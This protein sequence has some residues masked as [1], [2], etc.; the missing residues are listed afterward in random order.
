MRLNESHYLT[1][2]PCCMIGSGALFSA[3]YAAKFAGGVSIL[4]WIIGAALALL[5]AFML[6]EISTMYHQRGLF[7]R[8][9]SFSHHRDFGFVF[10]VSVWLG[11]VLTMSS[12]AV[13]TIQYL[14]TISPSWKPYLFNHDNLTLLG[15]VGVVV[16]I[17][18]YGVLNYWGMQVL[19]KTNNIMAVIKVAVPLIVGLLLLFSAF[20]KANFTAYH[21]S[22]AP[23]G[24]GHAFSA[25]ITCGIFYAFYGFS[26]IATF[27]SELKNPRRNIPIALVASVL[28][29]LLIYLL[30]QVSFIGA[31][32]PDMVK[33]GWHQLNFTSPLAELLILLNLNV[34]A[35]IL[36]FY[37]VISPSGAGI[38]YT[39]TGMTSF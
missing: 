28:I 22:F 14:S 26:S 8:L 36:Y 31:L 21:H 6:A 12:E 16:L 20:H 23:Y 29:C 38:T 7:A 11:V 1:A 18:L 15:T 24:V 37:A 39:G 25:V 27:G 17:I 19:S 2:A 35:C 30:L 3:Y 10:A 5:I 13:A 4:S 9:L 33:K 32:P 34:G